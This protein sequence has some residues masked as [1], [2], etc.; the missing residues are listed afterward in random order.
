MT[1]AVAARFWA[2]R[3]VFAGGAPAPSPLRFALAARSPTEGAAVGRQPALLP[4]RP[5]LGVTGMPALRMP[6]LLDATGLGEATPKGWAAAARGASVAGAA[7]MVT[8]EQARAR[9]T[10][11]KP[12]GVPLILRVSPGDALTPEAA[13]AAAA[14]G[15]DLA[16]PSGSPAVLAPDAL[17]GL[18]EA[19]RAVTEYRAPVFLIAAPGR[20]PAHRALQALASAGARGLCV[21]EPHGPHSYPPAALFGHAAVGR[22]AGAPMRSFVLSSEITDGP[23]LACALAAGHG[24]AA[25]PFPLRVAFAEE[26][27]T[28]ADWKAT[29]DRLA[30]ALRVMGDDAQRASCQAGAAD[31]RDLTFD[32]LR[33]LNYDAAALS[34]ARLAGF[35]ERLPWWAH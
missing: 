24:L 20:V 23:S 18:V 5:A 33:A 2:A 26:S 17:P 30:A 4:L 35:D 6:L 28:D 9:A 14:I 21:A 27:A 3:S 15:A 16:S 13:G 31:P 1:D 11:L 25:S 7:I 22:G 32:H 10:V 12:S 34:G 19:L 8:P 29:G